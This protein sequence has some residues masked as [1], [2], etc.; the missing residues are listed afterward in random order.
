MIAL[1]PTQV[2]KSFWSGLPEVATTTL[3]P[4]FAGEWLSATLP[5]PPVAPVTKTSA[6]LFS[7]APRPVISLTHSAAVESGGAVGHA[8]SQEMITS[9]RLHRPSRRYADVLA[10]PAGCIHAEIEDLRRNRT[11]LPIAMSLLVEL[12]TTP[13]GIDARRMRIFSSDSLVAGGKE[14]R[15]CSSTNNI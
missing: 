8:V 2:R 6:G 7:E 14:A 3:K 9:R 15:P 13:G 1:A 5:T 12:A 11:S 4:D 10:E